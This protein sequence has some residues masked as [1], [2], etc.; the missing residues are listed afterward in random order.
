MQEKREELSFYTNQCFEE[1]KRV[2]EDNAESLSDHF[3][4]QS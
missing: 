1:V 3:I 2:S 4:T